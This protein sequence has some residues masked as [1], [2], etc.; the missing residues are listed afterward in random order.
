MYLYCVEQ[1]RHLLDFVYYKRLVG[2]PFRELDWIVARRL[3]EIVV[4]HRVAAHIGNRCCRG[5]RR[6]AGLP[7]AGYVDDSPIAQRLDDI[8]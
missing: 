6:L 8:R 7:S 1:F 2:F 3:A 4:I 5:K